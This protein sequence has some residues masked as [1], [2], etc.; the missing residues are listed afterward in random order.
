M[1]S[2]V[3]VHEIA[4]YDEDEFCWHVTIMIGTCTLGRIINVIKESEMDRLL[5]P[6]AMVRASCL[7]S[8][9]G[10]VAEDPGAARMALWRKDHHT[11]APNGKG[12]E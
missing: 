11:R 2:R 10:T 1:I 8:R 9:Q 5:T 6:W 3:Q 7:L 4:C 12:P